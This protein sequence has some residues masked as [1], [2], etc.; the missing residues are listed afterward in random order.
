MQQR[1][2]DLVAVL[3]L[4]CK[5]KQL[6]DCEQ[7]SAEWQDGR[8][9]R[10]TASLFPKALNRPAE[11]LQSIEQPAPTPTP[12]QER[13]INREP[14]IVAAYCAEF[15]SI[16]YVKRVGLLVHPEFPFLGASP[17]RIVVD[18]Q[19]GTGLLEVKSLSRC[20]L[21][22]EHLPWDVQHQVRQQC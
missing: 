17:D 5:H 22:A 4:H 21:D 8:A 19:R 10:L 18:Q 16:A 6:K 20:N 13:G 2:N 11:L 12:A 1:S 7:G 14:K 15:S 9:V 3:Q